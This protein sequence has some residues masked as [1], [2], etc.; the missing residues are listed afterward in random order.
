MLTRFPDSLA[1]L[2]S[3]HRVPAQLVEAE[4]ARALE[5]QLA[6]AA[7]RSLVGVMNEFARPAT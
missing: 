2:L 4:R 1:Q 7:N 5:H 3:A 6:A